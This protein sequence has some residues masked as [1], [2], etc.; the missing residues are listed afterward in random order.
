V[1]AGMRRSASTEFA[2]ALLGCTRRELDGHARAGKLTAPRVGAEDWDLDELEHLATELE[3][4]RR[5]T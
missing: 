2:R 4:E 5:I 1:I 3:A